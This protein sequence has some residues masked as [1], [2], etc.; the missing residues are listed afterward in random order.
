MWCL[1]LISAMLCDSVVERKSCSGFNPRQS[2][3]LNTGFCLF[4][5]E[6]HA[7]AATCF[8]DAFA[9]VLIVVTGTMLKCVKC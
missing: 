2:R 3:N 4:A 8:A 9:V 1:C 6:L 7:E 5:I